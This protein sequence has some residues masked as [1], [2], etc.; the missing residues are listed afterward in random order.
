MRI[1]T[2]NREAARSESAEGRTRRKGSRVRRWRLFRFLRRFTS[3][4]RGGVRSCY[5]AREQHVE[6]ARDS[7]GVAHVSGIRRCGSPWS[8]P[9]CAPVVRERRAAEIDQG[10]G[11]WLADGGGAELVTVTTPHELG[12]RLAD[13]ADVVRKGWT[14]V[15][16]CPA[17]AGRK[18]PKGFEDGLRQTLGIVGVIKAVEVTY[19]RNGWHPHIHALVLTNEP[20]NE[21]QRDALRVHVLGRWQR[22]MGRKWCAVPSDRHGVDVRPVAENPAELAGYLTKV[23]GGWGA[24]LELAR[25][26][27]KKG[28]AG[29]VSPWELLD[30]A[31]EDG[32][33]AALELWHE[34]EQAMKGAR[35]IVWSPGLH[36]VLEV[37]EISDV[38]A[39][40]EP[41]EGEVVDQ[42]L[43]PARVWRRM[44]EDGEVPEFL[45][46]FEE[47]G[48]VWAE[49]FIRE[50]LQT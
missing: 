22:Y 38:E 15:V 48:P 18:T 32:D 50:R 2:K 34:Y 37:E 20:L 7:A 44:V 17:W 16:G 29:S 28:R 5:L 14:S 43:I 8:C 4:E 30:R 45:E 41:I 31:M 19:G 21:L 9:L 26:D 25:T 35:A 36:A 3:L 39:A 11:K 47:L 24:G 1:V 12:M 46:G 23:K 27:V 49:A 42:V 40:V 33:A 10:V 6:V 13:V